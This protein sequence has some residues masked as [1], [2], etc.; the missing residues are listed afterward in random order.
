VFDTYG[1]AHVAVRNE[2]LRAGALNEFLDV[3]V[4]P[5]VSARELD[6]G[7]AE[8]TAPPELVGGLDPEGAAAV[9]EFVRGGGT[10]VAV[11]SSTRWAVDLLRLPVVDVTSG[12]EGKEFSCP[13]SLL[14]AVPHG[15]NAI[16]SD[17]DETI[18]V[19]FSRGQAFRE[20][21]DKERGEAS[22][23]KRRVD[24]LLSYAPTRLLLSG[25]IQKPETIADR[26][27]WVRTTYGDG[28]VHLFGFRPQY[29]GWSQAT[30]QLLFRAILFD[31]R[32]VSR[33]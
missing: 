31:V 4:L 33:S 15:S 20:M 3:L 24:V 19:F 23:D 6:I 17:L 13:G 12:A 28:S 14:R 10:L 22:V 21:T 5:G 30:F 2:M 9:E 1:V 27:A 29:R 26:G 25:W 18:A 8:G 11:G 32:G 7:R 16:T